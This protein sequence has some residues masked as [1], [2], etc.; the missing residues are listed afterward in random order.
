MSSETSVEQ[1]AR[2]PVWAAAAVQAVLLTVL[3]FGYDYHRDEL[4][5]RMLEPAWGYVDQP[6]LTPAIARMTLHLADA[7]WA[8]RI[9][10]TLAS[11]LS[12][13]VLAMITW[14]LGGGRTAQT[15][16]AWG[17]ATAM[18]PLMLGHVLFTSTIDLLL[19]LL[20]AYALLVAVQGRDRWWLVAGLLAGLT[21]YNRW[22]IVT[23]VAG[24]VLGLLLLGPQRAFRT[25]WPYLGCVVAVIVGLP[26]VLYQIRHGWPQL[27]MGA[28][29]G[30]AHG[31]SVRS[32]FVVMMIVLLG[33]PLVAVWGTGV[34]WLLRSDRRHVDGWLVVGFAVLLVFTFVGGAQPHY[35]VHLLSVMYA[36]G[37]VPVAVWLSGNR[38]RRRLV[39]LVVAI[40]AAV[41]IVLALP[42]IPLRVVGPTPVVD[43]GPMVADQIGWSEYVEQIAKIYDA[44]PVPRPPILASNYGEAGALARYG[45]EFGL[46]APYS[47]HVALYDQRP[48]PADVDAVLVVGGQVRRAAKL[49]RECKVLAT[50]D[51]GLGV[52]NEEQGMPI[53][54]CEHPHDPERL[55]AELRHLE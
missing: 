28:A 3:S 17:Y 25:P 32:G 15:L 40:N 43:A 7:E 1:F 22:L 55:W 50:L 36:A 10:A 54:L 34:V 11:A 51:N 24:L 53:A 44:L 13:V 49:F 48:L 9:P 12:V 8:L 18:M 39:I 6:P 21:T 16:A 5:Y 4:Y 29:L 31:A 46:P 23:V 37:C 20:V 35:P 19:I 38:F 42:V 45:P 52:D 47:A 27:E 41:S 26:N 14:R 33:P 2:R 30:A